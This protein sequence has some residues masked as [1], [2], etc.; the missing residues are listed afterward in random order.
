MSGTTWFWAEPYF[1]FILFLLKIDNII[2]IIA[3]LK[4]NFYTDSVFNQSK[5]DCLFYIVELDY[6]LFSKT[7]IIINTPWL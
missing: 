5:G 7:I 6:F 4:S 2:I 3:T 1:S